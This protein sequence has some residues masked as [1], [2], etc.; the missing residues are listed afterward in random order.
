[1]EPGIHLVNVVVKD[2]F[3][4]KQQRD[5]NVSVSYIHRNKD[6]N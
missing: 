4:T 3:L 6:K 5:E 2:K 1:M